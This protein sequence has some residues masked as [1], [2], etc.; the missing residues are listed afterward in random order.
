MGICDGP[1]R[2]GKVPANGKTDGAFCDSSNRLTPCGPGRRS[3]AGFRSLVCRTRFAWTSP[4]EAKSLLPR[5]TIPQSA[6][7]AQNP[8]S[9]L[10]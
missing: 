2:F 3:R 6:T 5:H 8:V 10:T 7:L 9:E 4:F 1:A